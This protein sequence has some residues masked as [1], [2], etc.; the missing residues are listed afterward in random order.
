MSR[1]PRR[2]KCYKLLLIRT[3]AKS[4]GVAVHHLCSE[5]FPQSIPYQRNRTSN[6]FAEYCFLKTLQAVPTPTPFD[7]RHVIVVTSPWF[8]PAGWLYDAELRN[9]VSHRPMPT[10]HWD[11][12][13][14][15]VHGIAATRTSGMLF[16]W[17]Y[18]GTR[19]FDKSPGIILALAA[20]ESLVW[21]RLI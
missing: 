4:C 11:L 3:I 20:H 13:L 5:P 9:E 17:Y 12:S 19:L 15:L 2:S 21:L 16:P 7:V 1:L 10:L 6:T 18:F 14:K 8:L